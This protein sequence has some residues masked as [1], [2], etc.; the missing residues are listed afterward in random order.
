MLS[1][2]GKKVEMGM[3]HSNEARACIMSSVEIEIISL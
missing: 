2:P 3:L 1:L